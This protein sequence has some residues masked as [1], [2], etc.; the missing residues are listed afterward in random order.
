[1]AAVV[2][3]LRRAVE[4]VKSKEFR[5]YMTSTHFWGPVATW[6][7]PVAAFSDMREP[8][9]II[10]GRMTTAL[11]FYSMAFMRFAYRVQP[12]NL[13]LMACHGTNVM[14]Q[15]IQGGRY[16]IYHYGGSVTEATVATAA[17]PSVL[18][19]ASTVSTGSIAAT[20]ATTPAAEDP[21][22]DC[23]SATTPAA[24]DPVA[25]CDSAT[26]PA[27]E[28][29]VADCDSATTPAAEDPVADCDCL[30]VTSFDLLM[31]GHN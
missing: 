20:P 2:A 6:G 30:D 16:L 17:A 13:L 21:V 25:D 23:D 1:M 29:P 26:T 18:S 19:V 3:L 27:A 24:E 12:R 28:D 15:S 11:I 8:P 5:D 14:V 31:A 4:T 22:A 10:S 9:D 7:L